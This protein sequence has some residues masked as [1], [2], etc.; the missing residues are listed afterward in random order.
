MEIML[1]RM[2]LPSGEE[3]VCRMIAFFCRKG[4]NLIDGHLLGESHWND[5][6]SSFSFEMVWSKEWVMTCIIIFFYNALEAPSFGS[7]PLI[8]N[9][10]SFFLIYF[11]PKHTILFYVL[12]QSFLLC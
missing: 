6:L 8:H 2:M 11:I 12:I 3:C 1:R 7:S 9:V 10:I 5:A 4:P